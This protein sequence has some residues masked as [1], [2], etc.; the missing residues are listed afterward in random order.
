[1]GHILRQTELAFGRGH[2]AS[3]TAEVGCVLLFTIRRSMPK[4]DWLTRSE[5][6]KT[7]AHVPYRLLEAVPEHSYGDPNAENMLIQGDNL[8]AL[9]ALLPFYAGRVKSIFIDP[10]YNTRSAAIPEYDDNLEHT[11]WLA[12][13]YPRLQLL[14]SLLAENGSIW[15]TIDDHESHYLKVLMDE[16]FG[17]RNFIGEIAWQKRTSRENRA[18]I[19]S[20]HDTILLYARM[21]APQWKK[22]RNLQLPTGKGFSNPDHD[23]RG[24]WKSIPFTAQGFRENQMYP[25]ETPAGGTVLPPR[26]RCWAATEPE[27]LKLRDVEKK[28]YF[29]KK[30]TGRPRIKRFPWED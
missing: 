29:P 9:K 16:V 6:E 23:P 19:S 2:G 24:E 3:A 25:I 8:D 26:G 15:V 5:D 10:P 22:H 4:L 21:P 27:Y 28:V 11:V 12:L 20:A 18:A 17:R 14:R 13:M 7:A 1:M 30:G